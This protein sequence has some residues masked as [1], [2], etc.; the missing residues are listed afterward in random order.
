[1][2]SLS[3]FIAGEKDKITFA[4]RTP[5]EFIQVT[6]YAVLRYLAD[7]EAGWSSGEGQ[8]GHQAWISRC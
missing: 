3:C 4:I 2:A 5:S 1:M 7:F 8:E 6:C